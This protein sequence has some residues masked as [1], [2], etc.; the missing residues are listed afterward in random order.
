MLQAFGNTGYAKQ[1]KAA[2]PIRPLAPEAQEMRANQTNFLA[3]GGPGGAQEVRTEYMKLGRSFGEKG[4]F[5]FRYGLNAPVM[6]DYSAGPS[7]WSYTK[8]SVERLAAVI[9]KGGE[10]KCSPGHELKDGKCVPKTSDIV[11]KP[12][13]KK[14]G[15]VC[16]KDTG[17]EFMHGGEHPQDFSDV[18]KN[19]IGMAMKRSYLQHP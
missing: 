7:P 9:E 10:Q 1:Q 8:P 5:D 16:V 13:W 19:G 14:Q 18:Q 3:F 4:A 6:T 15:G 12:G 2:N 17:A 11:C